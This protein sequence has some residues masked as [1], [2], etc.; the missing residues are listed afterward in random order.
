MNLAGVM[1]GCLLNV[2]TVLV[3]APAGEG[4][5]RKVTAR[6]Q[7]RQGPPLGQPYYDLLKLLGKED[8]E[9]GTAPRMQR[10]A[11]CLSLATVLAVSC[12][13]PLGYAAPL[14]G[15]GDIMLLIYLL[16]LAGVGT[17]LAGLAAGST[18]SLLGVSREMMA[19]IT[20]EP[21]FAVA[22][23]LGSVQTGSF[24]LDSVLA[25]SVYV[26]GV[27]V[28]GA[29]MLLVMLFSFQAFVQ[30]VP[31]DMA[32]AETELM[33]GALLEYSG[34]KLALFKYAQ[35]ARLLVHSALFVTLFLPWGGDLPFPL[36]WLCFWAKVGVVVLAATVVGAT[37]A[38]YRVDKALRYFAGLLAVAL[39]A[40]GL[41]S[42]GY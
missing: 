3:L 9:S 31:F 4:L 18:Y 33:A 22:L 5:W 24:R 27:T 32:E 34:P 26:K 41:A 10:F 11:V 35:S 28:S 29:I 12:L 23:V 36:G 42:Y 30:R 21:L 2:V 6:I 16:T 8:I 17:L 40:L 20:L 37:H 19:M 38:R 7:S 13:I 25:G 39:L 14:N 1:L 15:A